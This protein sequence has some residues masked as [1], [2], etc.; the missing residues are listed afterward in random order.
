MEKLLEYLK[1]SYE[2]IL[3][4]H[5]NVTGANF[6]NDHEQLGKYYELIGEI[7]DEL[8]E[9]SLSI[10]IKEPTIEDAIDEFEVFDTT[11]R[12]S[13]ECFTLV[14]DIFNSVIG[15]INDI[16]D[17]QPQWLK[18]KLEEYQATLDLEA[19]YKIAHKLMNSGV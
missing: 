3:N 11:P 19:N 12:S 16:K 9:F 17:K 10:G 13:R 5:H 4:L 18:N 7:S 8:V 1:V 2:N 14:R 6:F 15:Y